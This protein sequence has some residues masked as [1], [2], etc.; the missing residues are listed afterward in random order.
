MVIGV[1]V[2]VMTG[3]SGLDN[4]SNQENKEPTE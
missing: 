1:I 2:D 3:G 4:L